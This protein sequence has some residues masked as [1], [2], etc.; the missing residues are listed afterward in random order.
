MEHKHNELRKQ[1]RNAFVD[2][3]KAGMFPTVDLV[4]N[5]LHY[6]R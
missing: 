1:V 3:E 5:Y 4:L 6:Q 2:D